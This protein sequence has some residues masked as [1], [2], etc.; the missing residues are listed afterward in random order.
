[1]RYIL[2]F[3]IYFL[4]CIASAEEEQEHEQEQE[5]E[6]ES[7]EI[8]SL[9]KFVKRRIIKFHMERAGIRY[10]AQRVSINSTL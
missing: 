1:M 9:D 10:S 3:S 8:Q 6:H 7:R 4:L 5:Q 2:I